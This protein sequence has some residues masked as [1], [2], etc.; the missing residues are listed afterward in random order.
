MRSGVV[1]E[2]DARRRLGRIDAQDVTGG[3]MQSDMTEIAGLV[4]P[5][6]SSKNSP[7]L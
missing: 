1:G 2:R 3:A 5:S 6:L 7:M 4:R